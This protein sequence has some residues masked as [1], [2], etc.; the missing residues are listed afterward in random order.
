MMRYFVALILFVITA[1]CAT[2]QETHTIALEQQYLEK[3]ILDG[4]PKF[5]RATVRDVFR[6]L[7]LSI[8]QHGNDTKAIRFLLPAS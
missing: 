2:Q 5:D 8:A 4:F 1:G 7:E 3:M 6:W